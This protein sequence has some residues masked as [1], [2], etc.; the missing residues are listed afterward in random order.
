[1]ASLATTMN[2]KA[3]LLRRFQD[4]WSRVEV[5]GLSHD[6]YLALR[7]ELHDSDDYRRAP[8]WVREYLRGYEDCWIEG[9]WRNKV[10]FSYVVDGRRLALDSPEY[11]AVEPRVVYE[12]AAETGAHIWRHNGRLFTSPKAGE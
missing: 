10:I 7:K 6:N 8:V 1:M 12:T 5:Y 4:I 11:K 3:R 2:R 9:V